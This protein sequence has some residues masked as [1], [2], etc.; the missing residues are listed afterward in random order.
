MLHHKEH[1]RLQL[2]KGLLDRVG[3]GEI[4]RVQLLLDL[5]S[6]SK[7]NLGSMPLDLSSYKF[8]EKNNNKKNRIG[9]A[10][11]EFQ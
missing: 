5:F 11:V 6:F 7:K 8:T 2:Q 9:L 3:A 10:T 1:Q 4:K